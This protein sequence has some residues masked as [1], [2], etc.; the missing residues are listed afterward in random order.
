MKKEPYLAVCRKERKEILDPSH[1]L[2][3]HQKL[4]GSIVGQE[5]SSIQESWKPVQEFLC[6]PADDQPINQ[7][8]DER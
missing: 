8:M 3:P 2:D 7:K 5:P 1:Y 6:N 4:M